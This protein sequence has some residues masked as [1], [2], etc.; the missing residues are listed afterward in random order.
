MIAL[1][2]WFVMIG[3]GIACLPLVVIVERWANDILER[4]N[5]ADE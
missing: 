4:Q 1:A 3:V 5:G 2:I